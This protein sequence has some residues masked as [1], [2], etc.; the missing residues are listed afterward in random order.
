M[1]LGLSVAHFS[2]LNHL[3]RLGDGSTPGQIASAFQVTKPTMTSTLSRL[4]ELGLVR[5][6][7]NPGD[8]RSKLVYLTAAGRSCRADAIAALKPELARLSRQL[9]VEAFVGMLPLL[10]QLRSHLDSHRPQSRPPRSSDRAKG[11]GLG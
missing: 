8:R 5:I 4:C 2:V 1:P 3:V 7:P 9:P 11:G 10:R 6:A